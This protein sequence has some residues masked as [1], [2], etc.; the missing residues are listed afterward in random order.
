MYRQSNCRKTPYVGISHHAFNRRC[1]LKS[2]HWKSSCFYFRLY[3]ILA[4]PQQTFPWLP[5]ISPVFRQI[6]RPPVVLFVFH[7]YWCLIA[8]AREHAL[9]HLRS[10]TL[11]P[12]V[13]KKYIPRYNWGM[14]NWG[15]RNGKSM[16][17]NPFQS[18]RSWVRGFIS[19]C[20][21]NVYP[22]VL[23]SL[24][25]NVFLQGVLSAQDSDGTRFGVCSGPVGRRQRCCVWM[26]TSGT[27]ASATFLNV[28]VLGWLHSR[29]GVLHYP[30]TVYLCLFTII[31]CFSL[32]KEV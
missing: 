30:S 9:K 7:F 20:T 21:R 5:V 27:C 28:I 29:H 31:I 10:Q 3:S 12:E 32:S 15:E 19:T 18:P 2:I 23:V 25:F 17:F 4:N 13:K 22:Q 8:E 11:S 24:F 6:P 26:W 16:G 14:Q 1:S